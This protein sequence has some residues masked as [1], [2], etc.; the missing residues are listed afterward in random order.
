MILLAILIAAQAAVP[1]KP[2]A[3][4]TTETLAV[5]TLFQEINQVNADMGNFQGEIIKNH[6]GYKFDFTT[7]TLVEI[8]KPP[9]PAPK[10]EKTEPKK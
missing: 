8:P 9:A 10:S 7:G 3:L 2:P 1:V 6:P 4:T 5:K